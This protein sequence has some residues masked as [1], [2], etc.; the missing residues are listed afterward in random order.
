MVVAVTERFVASEAFSFGSFTVAGGTMPSAKLVLF[1][2]VVHKA[3]LTAGVRAAG[4]VLGV[5]GD[6][7]LPAVWAVEYV[8]AFTGRYIGHSIPC[9]LQ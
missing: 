6:D 5:F 9:S 2:V 4:L 3:L 1:T 7:F 8:A